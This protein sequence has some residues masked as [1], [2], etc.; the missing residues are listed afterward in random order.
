MGEVVFM[1]SGKGG[2]GKS[3][4]AVNMAAT[5]AKEGKKVILVDMNMGQGNLD[6][7]LGLQDS[8]VY[9]VYD[10]LTGL[11]KVKQGMIRDNRFSCMYLMAAPPFADDG[12]VDPEKIKHLYRVLSMYFDFVII[13]G[14]GGVSKDMTKAA[15][16]ADRA[17][18]VT[19]GDYA[20]I[21]GA[22]IVEMTLRKKGIGN[23][24]Y[25][26]N[27]VKS[28]HTPELGYPSFEDIGRILR[29][30]VSGIIQEDDSIAVSLNRG[31]PA[32]MDDDNALTDNMK[33]ITG[34]IMR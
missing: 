17:I 9:N 26:L 29:G 23:I 31:I 22:E 6:L 7:Y 21:R 28:E 30:R 16:G 12:E 19:T 5:L 18:V 8:T 4:I 2:S 33:R 1:A 11:C 32:V 20:G 27:R 3:A 24:S 25:M 14:P 34:R 13:D 15:G 10:V